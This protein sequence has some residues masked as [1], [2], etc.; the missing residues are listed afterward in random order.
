MMGVAASA[1]Y[2]ARSRRANQSEM[3]VSRANFIILV[4]EF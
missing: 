3:A 4:N 2:K 1:L